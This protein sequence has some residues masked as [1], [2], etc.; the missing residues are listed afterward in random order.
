MYIK[1]VATDLNC[2]NESVISTIASLKIPQKKR[3]SL[4][5]YIF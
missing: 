5:I 4:A 1:E 2:D 3:V